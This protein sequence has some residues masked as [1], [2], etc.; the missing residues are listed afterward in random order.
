MPF[1]STQP[2]LVPSS[3]SQLS[4]TAK[5]VFGGRGGGAG[6]SLWLQTTIELA[7]LL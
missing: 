5:Q 1:A 2:L 6:D 4:K 3:T 7:Q